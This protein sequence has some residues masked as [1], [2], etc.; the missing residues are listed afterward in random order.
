MSSMVADCLP[1][2][3][4]HQLGAMRRI[5]A[6]LSVRHH[7]GEIQARQWRWSVAR[8]RSLCG[9]GPAF[10]VDTGASVSGIDASLPVGKL[11]CSEFVQTAGGITVLKRFESGAASIGGSPCRFT[12]GLLSADLSDIR[13]LTGLPIEGILGMDI[14]SQYVL[15]LDFERGTAP[16]QIGTG[17]HLPC[18]SPFG[19]PARRPKS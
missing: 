19:S 4:S 3:S 15:H 13:G 8:S 12:D 2:S 17:Q 1:A 16:S 7:S 9:Q 14:L 6:Q 10:V 5:Q 11:M 18:H